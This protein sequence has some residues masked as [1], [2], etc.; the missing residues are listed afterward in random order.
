MTSASLCRAD[1]GL[2][3]SGRDHGVARSR[4]PRNARVAFQEVERVSPNDF[5][6]R[7]WPAAVLA[8]MARSNAS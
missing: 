4:R 8:P 5:A 3:A 7:A 2:S 6:S 1:T